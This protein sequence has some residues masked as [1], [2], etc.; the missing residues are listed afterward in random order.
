DRFQV[1]TSAM[2]IRLFERL[3]WATRVRWPDPAR[4][5]ARRVATVS[6]LRGAG[7]SS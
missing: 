2:I 6:D 4:L 5:D 1:D 3:G 7:P